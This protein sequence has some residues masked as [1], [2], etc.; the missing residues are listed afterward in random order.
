MGTNSLKN[1]NRRSM[2]K[3]SLQKGRYRI[4]T[5][6]EFTLI[7]LLVVIAIIAILA[8]MLLPALNK[9]REKVRTIACA[10]NLKQIGLAQSMYTN[11]NIEYIVSPKYDSITPQ[12]YYMSFWYNKLSGVGHD[13]IRH[14]NGYGVSYFGKFGTPKGSFACPSETI[15]FGDLPLFPN[16]HYGI[17]MF[18][19]RSTV[20]MTGRKISSVISA[21]KAIF[22]TDFTNTGAVLYSIKYSIHMSYRHGRYI[23]GFAPGQSWPGTANVLYLDGHVE[24]K[25]IRKLAKEDRQEPT[26]WNSFKTGLKCISTE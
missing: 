6:T 17:N 26:Q 8:G 3:Y 22:A 5:V 25:D 13:N 11:E 10:N 21:S 14:S 20:A 16:T 24:N 19:Y 23:A 15:A 18:M 9:A 7:E 4:S 1:G 12:E 2:R